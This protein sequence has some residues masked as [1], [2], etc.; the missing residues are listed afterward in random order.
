MCSPYS[1]EDVFEGLG[2]GY[3][4]RPK[5]AT[6]KPGASSSSVCLPRKTSF[7]HPNQQEIEIGLCM[8]YM[9]GRP[10]GG[11]RGNEGK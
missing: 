3:Y 6:E 8:A 2:C 5:S 1:P 10:T 4:T 9:A 11:V 7:A